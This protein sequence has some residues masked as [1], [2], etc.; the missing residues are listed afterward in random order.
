MSL[1]LKKFSAGSG[2]HLRKFRVFCK[3]DIFDDFC[4]NRKNWNFVMKILKIYVKFGLK[5]S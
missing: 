3:N 1:F 5:N 4:K 2:A